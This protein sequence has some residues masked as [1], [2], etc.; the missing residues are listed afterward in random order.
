MHA[1]IVYYEYNDLRTYV[2]VDPRLDVGF[3]NKDECIRAYHQK[4]LD[5]AS[6][7][8]LWLGG[9]HDEALLFRIEEG[10]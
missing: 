3:K 6:N 5:L 4:P 10:I 8:G 9:R 1:S 7:D 2:L